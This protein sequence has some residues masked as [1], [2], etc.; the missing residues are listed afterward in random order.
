MPPEKR[1]ILERFTEK[2]E[3]GLKDAGRLESLRTPT[4]RSWIPRSQVLRLPSELQ[5]IAGQYRV[6]ANAIWTRTR[7]Y[8]QAAEQAPMAAASYISGGAL[9]IIILLLI[10]IFLTGSD[11]LPFPMLRGRTALFRPAA[12]LEPPKKPGFSAHRRRP[13]MA[14]RMRPDHRPCLP[15]GQ[16][17]PPD[18]SRTLASRRAGIPIRFQFIYVIMATALHLPRC[19]RLA[20]CGR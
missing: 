20:P 4:A 14:V 10:I 6:A 13:A 3:T 19:P 11:A 8:Q 7:A 5:G 16:P 15:H 12:P 9:I 2:M 1:A 17:P 18:T